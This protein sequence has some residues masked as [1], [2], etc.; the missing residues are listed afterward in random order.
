VALQNNHPVPVLGGRRVLM[1]YP[2]WLWSQGVPYGERQA[3]VGRILALAPDAGALLRRY[4][5]DFVTVGPA[6]RKDFGAD[7]AA[8]RARYPRVIAT[9]DY[10][11]FDVRGARP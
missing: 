4:H 1:S 6:E 2:G 7:P 5:V 8:W 3:E 11:V 9:R 10:E